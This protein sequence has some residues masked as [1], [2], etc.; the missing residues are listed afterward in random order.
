MIMTRQPHLTTR[1][2]RRQL[3]RLFG[4]QACA[5]SGVASVEL[6]IIAPVLVLAIVGTADLGFGIYRRMQVQAAAQAGAEYA[7][8]KGFSA[9]GISNAVVSATP[10]TGVSA[11]P[12]PQQFCGCPTATGI[13]AISCNAACPDQSKPGAYVVVSARG[14]YATI[15]PYP[16]FPPT[17][18]LS[19]TSTARIQ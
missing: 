3:R 9:S 11:S 2:L 16:T 13:T 15:L 18:E 4:T 17:F 1:V 8:V 5:T 19:A 10:F 6:A 7:I 14:S 12:E